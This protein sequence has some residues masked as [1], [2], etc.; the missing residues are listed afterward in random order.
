MSLHRRLLRKSRVHLEH[1]LERGEIGLDGVELPHVALARLCR[2]AWKA[3]VFVSAMS[4]LACGC[5][6]AYHGATLAREQ[7]RDAVRAAFSESDPS[8]PCV[9]V[10][11][12]VGRVIA[13]RDGD[14]M[15]ATRVTSK[16]AEKTRTVETLDDAACVGRRVRRERHAAISVDFVPL[17]EW[18]WGYRRAASF[19]KDAAVCV[20]HYVD[21]LDGNLHCLSE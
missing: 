1:S 17:D 10:L 2:R 19:T 14:V 8:S 21:V 18:P 9:R 3:V 20:Q 6:A 5:F 16:S 13:L 7:T 4:L 15:V 12:D 11:A